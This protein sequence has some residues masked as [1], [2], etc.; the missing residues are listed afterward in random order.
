MKTHNELVTKLSFIFK[1][2]VC[3]LAAV[4]WFFSP[5][6]SL[7][8]ELKLTNVYHSQ[9]TGYYCGPAT[10]Q[11]ILDSTTVNIQ[12]LPTQPEIM[13]KI[14][15]NNTNWNSYGPNKST[16]PDGLRGALAFYDPQRTYVSYVKDTL[17]AAN[18]KLAY[19]LDTF[20]VPAAALINKGDHWINVRGIKTSAQPTAQGAYDINGFFV[21]DPGTWGSALG[22][23]RYLANNSGGWQKYF[24]PSAAKWTGPWD[25]KY[26]VVADP[27]DVGDID[28]VPDYSPAGSQLTAQQAADRALSELNQISELANEWAFS[29][30]G[31]F[32]ANQS[33][34]MTWFDESLSESDWLV[35]FFNSMNSLT[36]ALIIDSYTGDIHQA[37]WIEGGDSSVTMNDLG[38]IYGNE[39][40]GHFLS[41]NHPIPEPHSISLLI[42]G[43][44]TLYWQRN[45]SSIG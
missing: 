2:H 19:N 1:N 20:D 43:I 45:R 30:G 23:N 28:T 26:I 3:F 5:A 11:M 29:N 13:A 14:V 34:L 44:A 18:R 41:D 21:R 16:D 27:L 31:T 10:A 40:S 15:Q 4:V 36:G 22:R 6:V 42:I 32:L 24:T 38:A 35:P 37:T 17:D 12:P 8:Y 7:G 39:Y 25:N 9:E 33:M